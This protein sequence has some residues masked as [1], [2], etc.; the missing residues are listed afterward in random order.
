MANKE[1]LKELQHRL[2]ERMQ[3]AR[4]Q[5]STASWLA[6]EAAGV[7]L[8]FSLGQAAEIFTP[9]PM[10]A[11]PYAEPWLVGVANLR[12]GLYTVVDLAAF[13]GLR[14][15]GGAGSGSRLVTLNPELHMNCALQVDK[16]LGLRGNDQLQPDA[17]E[18]PAGRPRYAGALMRDAEGRRWQVLDLEALVRN[19][20]F[21]RI[22]V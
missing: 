13:L 10:K 11:V 15:A 12:G 1:A 8:L 3:A 9:V 19:E 17:G 22:V 5:P 7:G 2:A 20:R 6:V 14:E 16:L 4:E 21:V 18:L